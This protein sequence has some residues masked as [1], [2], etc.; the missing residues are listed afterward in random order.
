MTAGKKIIMILG[1]YLCTLF[2]MLP[3]GLAIPTT[4][5]ATAIGD[6]NVTLQGTGVTGSVGWFAWGEFSGN[7]I[8]LTKNVTAESGIMNY[9][10]TGTPLFPGTTF[11]YKACDTTGCG[12]QQSFTILTITPLPT[13]TY[14]QAAEAIMDSGFSPVVTFYAF[15]VPFIAIT[16]LTIFWG[17]I[18]GMIFVGLWLRTRGTIIATQ[19]WMVFAGFACSATAGLA[20]GLP[21]EL[22]ALAQALFYTSIA[23]AIVAYTFK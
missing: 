19:L 3:P 9:T 1:V 17:F 11:Y 18:I 12:A 21:P 5:A 13:T 2:C 7:C 16:G 15:L 8:D 20:I 23:G 4:G 6:N 14:G 10:L 22:V